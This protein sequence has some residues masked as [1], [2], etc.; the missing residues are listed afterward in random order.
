MSFPLGLH[1]VYLMV[2]LA[3]KEGYR[4]SAMLI[5]YAISIAYSDINFEQ[6]A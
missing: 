3:F 2:K 6:L 5:P 1:G 4:G